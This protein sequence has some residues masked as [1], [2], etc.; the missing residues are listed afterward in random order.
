[1]C[2]RD[3]HFVQERIPHLLE[4]VDM[5]A[6]ADRKVR[7]YS[8]GMQQRIGLAQ[9]MVHEPELMIL[10]EPFA[11]AQEHLA[12]DGGEIRAALEEIERPL[13]VSRRELEI[14]IQFADEVVV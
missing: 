10:D 9:A 13:E 14:D 6:G 11:V 12:A 3:K 7:E 2:G 5:T 4:A 1:M 8:K